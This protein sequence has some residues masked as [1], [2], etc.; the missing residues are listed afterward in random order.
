[1]HKI[2]Q[3]GGFLGRLLGPLL[4]TGM[5]LMENVVKPLAKRGLIQLGLIAAV[6]AT[7]AAIHKK[8]FGSG[9]RS[10]DFASRPTT[11]II[12]NE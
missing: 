8:M 3:S 4:K 1:M 11:L 2:G 5:L 7:G 6:S 9:R 12:L 10:S